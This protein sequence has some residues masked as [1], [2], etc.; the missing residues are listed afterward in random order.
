MM[1]TDTLRKSSF[2]VP[3][4]VRTVLEQL[5]LILL[6]AILLG[7][8]TGALRP[9]LSVLAFAASFLVLLGVAILGAYIQY[10]QRWEILKRH[11]ARRC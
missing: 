7:L 6:G 8:V 10:S 9:Q 11:L 1:M 2:V 5:Q 3:H 4:I